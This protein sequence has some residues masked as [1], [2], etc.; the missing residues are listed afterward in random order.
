[1]AEHLLEKS[2]PIPFRNPIASSPAHVMLFSGRSRE[3]L[4]N[5]LAFPHGILPQPATTQPLLQ[6]NGRYLGAI[7]RLLQD[8]DTRQRNALA[9]QTAKDA[10]TTT[11][12]GSPGGAGSAGSIGGGT[13]TQSGSGGGMGSACGS[14][15]CGC[16]Q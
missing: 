7:E 9:D 14:C 3:R 13:P 12:R 8:E 1:M 10:R 2:G 6:S 15:G 5:N 16:G 11:G 4:A